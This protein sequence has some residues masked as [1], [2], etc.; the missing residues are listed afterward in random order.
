MDFCLTCHRNPENEL[1]PLD[2]ITDL[3]Y[4]PDPRNGESVSEAQKRIG[5]ELKLAWKINPP[6]KSCAGCHR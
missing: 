2:K 3:G 5:T 6:D 1:R 4:Q